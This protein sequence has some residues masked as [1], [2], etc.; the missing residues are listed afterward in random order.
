MLRNPSDV[1]DVLQN[2]IMAAFA[3]FDCYAEGTNFRAWI[4]RF[5]T[6]EIFNRN[7][8][9]QP[10]PASESL[11]QVQDRSPEEPAVAETRWEVLL[12][13][14]ELLLDIFEDQVVA[15]LDQLSTSERAV[16][17][18]RAIGDFSY[19]EIHGIL[20]MP[21]GSVMGYLSR[22]RQKLR[23]SLAEYAIE[24]GYCR[25]NEEPQP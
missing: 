13:N 18:L 23:N 16:L 15:A 14:P 7:R 5:V 17:L 21:V 19:Q 4:F 22:A 2:A 11:E 10:T 12:D 1:E 3:R 20:S 6:L 25:R 24:H 9:R 8:H